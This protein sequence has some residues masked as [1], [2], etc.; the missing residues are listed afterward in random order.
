M[1]R[2]KWLDNGTVRESTWG[3]NTIEALQA[4][5]EYLGAEYDQADGAWT[6]RAPETGEVVLV[7][8]DDL[9]AAG[10]AILSGAKDWYTIW[11]AETGA[12]AR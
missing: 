5:V 7:D 4:A 8:E 11:C 3:G 9:M 10:A 2:F 12:P 1:I 6:Y